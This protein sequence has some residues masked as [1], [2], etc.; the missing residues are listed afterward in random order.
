MLLQES[1]QSLKEFLVVGVAG[2]SHH[3][4]AVESLAHNR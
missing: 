1:I 2:A 3:P 4:E